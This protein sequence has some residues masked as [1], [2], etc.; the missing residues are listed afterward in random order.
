MSFDMGVFAVIAIGAVW[1]M[2]ATML[3]EEHNDYGGEHTGRSLAIAAVLWLVGYA[4]V[5]AIAYYGVTSKDI[6]RPPDDKPL[7]YS[8]V[9]DQM[10]LNSGK[11][12]PLTLGGRV[13]GS[14]GDVTATTSV[15][16][17]MFS[18]RATTTLQA[19]SSPASAV[20]L[21]YTYFG[22]TYILELVTSHI[23]FVLS[24]TDSPTVAIWMSNGTSFKFGANRY[25]PY[26]VLKCK[27]TFHDLMLMCLWPDYNEPGPYPTVSKHAMD[28][29][30]APV[31]Q[32]GL[33]RATITLPPKMYRQLLGII[34]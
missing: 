27:T 7:T 17:G 6:P 24:E 4:V 20:S 16:S 10:G 12:Y 28:V 9:A 22:K 21:G 14:S 11:A 26:S 19:S 8:Y 18:A 23:T 34:E 1:A 5:N 31:V 32:D 33:D 25:K 29:G 2:F 15:S 13:G 30:L 3:T